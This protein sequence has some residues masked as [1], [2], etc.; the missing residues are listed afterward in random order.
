MGDHLSLFRVSFPPLTEEPAM[1]VF[2]RAITYASVFVGLLLVVV[3]ARILAPAGI[4]RPAALGPLELG[5]L[6]VAILGAA[7]ALWCVLTFALVGKGTPAPFDPPRRL[8][9]GGPYRWIRNPM[10]VGAGLALA[11]AALVYRS[12]PL[13]AYDAGFMLTAH[14]FVIL[15][16][17]PTL[18]RLFGPAYEAYRS[19][20]PRWLPRL[21]RRD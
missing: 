10:Y 14:L 12:L 5:G 11:G 15:Y 19:T 9:T 2:I 7:I 21:N 20:V 4:I 17:E 18:A 16:E 6:G 3:P 13:L 1:F 8:V